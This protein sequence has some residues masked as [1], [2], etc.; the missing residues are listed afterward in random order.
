MNNQYIV[1]DIWIGI[2]KVGE[3]F[4]P[5][6]LFTS[7]L[8]IPL[9]ILIGKENISGLFVL[10]AYLFMILPLLI[11]VYNVNK[12]FI[13]KDGY[14]IF[15]ARD[16]ENSIKDIITLKTVQ[17]FFYSK[18]IKLSNIKDVYFNVYGEYG[19]I[20]TI[21]IVDNENSN[22]LIFSSLQKRDEFYNRLTSVINVNEY[23]PFDFIDGDAY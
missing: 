11:R 20:F 12:Q 10:N 7:T 14:L 16:V 22:N 19:K 21:T 4:L 13:I 8:I 17:G 1:K 5:T 2:E 9:I 23:R 6:F 15:P 18:K 3:A